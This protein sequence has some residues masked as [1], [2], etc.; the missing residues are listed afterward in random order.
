MRS[1]SIIGAGQAGLQLGIGL[2]KLGYKVSIYTRQTAQ[3]VLNGF[4]LSS[5][6]MFHSALQ[7]ERKLGL[8][9]WD[10]TCPENKTVTYTLSKAS[11]S[12][13]AI[14]WQGKISQFYQAIDQ[15]LKFSRWMEEFTR[16]GGQLIVQTVETQDLN[17]IMRHQDLT[18]VSGG[19]GEISQLFPID[20]TRSSFNK[21]QR[22]LCCLYV[23]DVEAIANS[24][25]VRA[26]VIPGIGEYFITPGLTLTGPCE[27]MLFEG[28]PGGPFDCWKDILKPDQ[29]LAKACELLKKYVPWEAELCHKVKL[30]DQKATLQGS[31]IPIVRKPTFCLS[32]GKPLLGLGDSILLNDPI[33]GQGANNASQS[34]TFYL[35]KIKEH[36]SQ[37]FD[38]KWMQETFEDYWKQSAQLATKWTNLM[39]NPTKSFVSLLKKASLQPN[40]ANWLADGFNT[41]K[42][43]LTEIE[44]KK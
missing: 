31:Y 28:L 2:L 6:S 36:K 43:I 21:I 26:N 9:F 33:G 22:V 42:K 38:E 25:G 11:K 7:N 19:K 13:I 4:I 44:Y 41:P 5:P 16:L 39:L 23:K 14:H 12:E 34:A 24:Q 20:N 37:L 32:P 1:I 15:R 10:K 17:R 40:V 35:S 8:N 30:T 27:M 29:R 3:E 18:V